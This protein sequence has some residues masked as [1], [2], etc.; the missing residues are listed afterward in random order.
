MN[1]PYATSAASGAPEITILHQGASDPLLEIAPGT[2]LSDESVIDARTRILQTT[3]NSLS[4]CLSRFGNFSPTARLE[5]VLPKSEFQ[6]IIEKLGSFHMVDLSLLKK[7]PKV[8]DLEKLLFKRMWEKEQKNIDRRN[9]LKEKEVREEAER[10]W[11][12]WREMEEA[13]RLSLDPKACWEDYLLKQ[14]KT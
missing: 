8:G 7:D 12:E 4:N 11:Q 1:Y 5:R 14:K 6:T 2:V 9:H 13:R 10:K 3:K